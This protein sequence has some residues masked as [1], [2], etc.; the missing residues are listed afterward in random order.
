MG[1]RENIEQRRKL[2]EDP[3]KW[4]DIPISRVV[5]ELKQFPM[6]LRSN[7]DLG[8]IINIAIPEEARIKPDP[9]MAE[10][11][12]FLWKDTP[13]HMV[14]F[15]YHKTNNLHHIKRPKAGT[16]PFMDWAETRDIVAQIDPDRDKRHDPVVITFVGYDTET[17]EIVGANINSY[18]TKGTYPNSL[19]TFRLGKDNMLGIEDVFAAAWWIYPVPSRNYIII[20]G[21]TSDKTTRPYGLLTWEERKTYLDGDIPVGNEG[22]V[23]PYPGDGKFHPESYTERYFHH[24]S[25]DDLAHL[26]TFIRR[27]AKLELPL[28]M[29]MNEWYALQMVYLSINYDIS[30][31]GSWRSKTLW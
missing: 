8:K 2:R 11:G 14:R 18:S 29:H 26:R 16:T 9:K 10:D 24:E 12:W 30:K 20:P 21:D 15:T 28:S 4:L 22:K 27:A 25:R 19:T 6:W 23:N 31:D 1:W 7:G 3:H 5:P 13:E 17:D